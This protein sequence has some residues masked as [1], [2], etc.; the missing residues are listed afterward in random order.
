VSSQSPIVIGFFVFI[1]NNLYYLIAECRKYKSLNKADV[2]NFIGFPGNHKH[3]ESR[4]IV[5][6]SD[7]TFT[8]KHCV[9]VHKLCQDWDQCSVNCVVEFNWS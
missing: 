2:I 3:N 6:C 9:P 5:I 4:R 8:S 1:Y 7:I